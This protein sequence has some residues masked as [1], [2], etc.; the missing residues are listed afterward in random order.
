MAE[1]ATIEDM[2]AVA[3]LKG[4]RV[5]LVVPSY[6]AHGGSERH[7]QM[8]VPA[9]LEVGAVVKVFSA[10]VADAGIPGVEVRPDALR[11]SMGPWSRLRQA[12]AVAA[13]A[14]EI[15]SCA[16]VVEFQRVAPSALCGA[17]SRRLPTMLS[18]YTPEHTCPS[19]GR[20]LRRSSTVCDKAPGLAC[21][22]VDRREHCLSFQDGRPFNW[23]D[24]IRS[25]LQLRRNAAQTRLLS[26]ITFN[27]RAMAD[28]YAQRVGRPMRS[29]VV[30]PPLVIGLPT[31]R[32]RDAKRL[33]YAGRIEEFKG[34]FD[35]VP[36]LAALTECTLDV[37]GDGSSLATLRAQVR[38]A[39][40]ESRVRFHGWLERDAVTAMFASATIALVPS[41][42][43]E[44]W[45]MVGPEAIARG[46]PVVAYDSGGIGEWCL[47]QFGT[48]VSVGDVRGL[49][50]A[51]RLWLD[52]MAVGLDTSSWCEEAARRW[53]MPRFL[54]EYARALSSA[55]AAF[56]CSA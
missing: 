54:R 4:L 20:Y 47:P 30:C 44:A 24:R 48:L 13:L 55:K 33:V 34:V 56:R 6:S 7:L 28:L 3:A 8:L 49:I 27:S 18:V 41:R 5:A 36:A 50:D 39:G 35:L 11:D 37:V 23:R 51:S 1:G 31:A 22:N 2:Q 46:C 14:D 25:L 16:D 26:M 29:H 45:G 38:T 40:L 19:R 32:A 12:G 9:L 53:G 21:L 10:S 43:F 17:L 42:C 52:R 15:V